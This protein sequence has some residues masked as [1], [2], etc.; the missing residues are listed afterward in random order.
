MSHPI[1]PPL[2][3]LAQVEH[4]GVDPDPV[5]VPGELLG[6]VRLAPGGEADHD[7]DLAHSAH[8]GPGGKQTWRTLQQ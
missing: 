1:L 7:N 4:P 2:P 6:D 3:V 8:A 5:E